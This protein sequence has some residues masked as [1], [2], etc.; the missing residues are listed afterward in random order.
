MEFQCCKNIAFGKNLETSQ[1]KIKLKVLFYYH[2]PV[3]SL[4]LLLSRTNINMLSDRPL[5]QVIS[6]LQVM[7]LECVPV[8]KQVERET[9]T[10]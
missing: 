6:K 3:S 2:N 9:K 7:S 5:S 4:E 1:F 10:N 8:I